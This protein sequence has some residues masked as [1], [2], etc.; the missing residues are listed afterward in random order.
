MGKRGQQSLTNCP[1]SIPMTPYFFAVFFIADSS[2][3]ETAEVTCLHS[4]ETQ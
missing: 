2:V 1:S 4:K 3:A